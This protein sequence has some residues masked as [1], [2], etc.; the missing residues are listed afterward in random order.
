[1]EVGFAWPDPEAAIK[2]AKQHIDRFRRRIASD[3]D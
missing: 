2:D 1:M 3:E